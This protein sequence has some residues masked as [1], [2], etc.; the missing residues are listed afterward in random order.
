MK[1][2]EPFDYEILKRKKCWGGMDLSSTSDMSC[3]T[4]I[5]PE[6][7]K[8]YVKTWY[9]LPEF[10]GKNSADKN[11]SLYSGWVRDKWITETEGNVIDYDQITEKILYLSGENMIQKVAYDAYNGAAVISSLYANGIAAEAYSQQIHKLNI[12]T[13]ELLRQVKLKN[14]HHNND[15]V[16]RWAVSNAETYKSTSRDGND[17][18]KVMKDNKHPEKKVDPVVSLIM[19]LGQ[20]IADENPYEVIERSYYETATEIKTA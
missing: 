5:F 3:F 20:W 12:P 2:G 10:K 11:N 14:I 18:I 8:I 16:L 4:L 6:L 15:P 13:K 9:W 17:N 7:P 1:S 19:A